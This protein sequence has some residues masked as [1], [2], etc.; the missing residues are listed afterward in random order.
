M[1][2]NR[3]N[4]ILGCGKTMNERIPQRIDHYQ[5]TD[6]GVELKG[7]IDSKDISKELPRLLE[8]IAGKVSNVSYQLSFDKDMLGNRI[9]TGKIQSHVLLDCQRCMKEFQLDLNCD[10]SIAFVHNDYEQQKAE[11]SCYEVFWL[12]EKELFDP[13]ILIEDE[14]LLTMPQIPKHPESEIGRACRI[15]LDYPSENQTG[16]SQLSESE[17]DNDDA[18]NPF[19]VLKQ[20]K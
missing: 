15:T 11:D 5:Y 10:V 19:A 16:D 20:L 12:E 6:K 8:Y 2:L 17:R 7:V 4:L 13:R 18:N 9:V 3:F 1:L 14:L